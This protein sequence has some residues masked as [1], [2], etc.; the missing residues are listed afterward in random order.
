MTRFQISKVVSGSGVLIAFVTG[1]VASATILPFSLV[2]TL[3]F[4]IAAAKIARRRIRDAQSSAAIRSLMAMGV[5]FGGIIAFAAY[6]Q[7]AKTVEQELQRSISLP[8]AEMSLAELA[9]AMSYDRQS[10][11]I[12]VTLR[13]PDSA[14]DQV[15][16]WPSQQVSVAEF[17]G[18]IESQTSLR[19]SFRHC[20]N[21][22]TVLHGGDCCFGL[23]IRDSI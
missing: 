20:G 14:K 6:Y 15:I 9:Y 2:A 1:V 8:S 12:H 5:V 3:I 22:Y 10:Y 21:G 19:G 7:P 23:A 18:A 13:F 4:L 17:L 16:R 11:P